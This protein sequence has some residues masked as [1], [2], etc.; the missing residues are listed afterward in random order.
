MPELPEVEPT[1]RGI[2]P[3]LV[4]QRISRLDVHQPHLRWPVP[5]EIRALQGS[6]VNAVNRRGKYLLVVV[7]AGQAILHLGM[8]GSLRICT[9]DIPRRKH[10]H[11]EL[12]LASGN[13]LRFHDPR[14]FGCMLWQAADA[15]LHALLAQLGPE[16]L[17]KEFDGEYLFT[18][19]RRRTVAIKNL[20]M[21]SHIVVGVGNIYASESLFMAGIR[22]GKAARRISRV[23]AHKLVDAIKE[24]LQQ[25]IDK[26][27][28]T[29]KDFVNGDGEPGYFKQS[30]FVYGRAGE[31]CRQC[32]GVIKS[33][34][35]GQRSTFYCAVCQL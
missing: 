5:N 3:H 12:T 34:V 8:S 27:G 14:R 25:S 7:P 2:E 19:T 28:T 30:L 6:V 31:A 18:A 22:P 9:A 24:V 15:P 32:G 29:L 10:D 33:R 13:I 21:N 26:G 16:P 20:I 11:V 17:A 1:R 4:G 23:E 35:L